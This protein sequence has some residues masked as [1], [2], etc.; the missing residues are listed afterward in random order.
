VWRLAGLVAVGLVVV[1]A[2]PGLLSGPDQRPQPAADVQPSTPPPAGVVGP[3]VEHVI[4]PLRWE[5]RGSQVRS[6]FAIAAV[7]RLS[8]LRQGVDTLLW[9][10]T[11]DGHDHVAVISYR[12]QP[13]QSG[14]DSIEVAALRVRQL[15]D[16]ATARS[17]TI[18]YVSGPD[19]LVG[20]AWQGQDLHTR[21]LVLSRPAPMRL[22]VSSLIDYHADGRISR[23]WQG[24]T[25]HDGVAVTDLGRH[26]DPVII[27][28]AQDLGSGI[29]PTLVEVGGRRALPSPGEVTVAGVSAASYAGPDRTVLVDG[30]ARAVGRLFDLRHADARVL[31][32]GRLAGGLSDSGQR[33]AGRGALVLVR[34]DDGATFQAFVFADQ[35][36]QGESSIANAVRWSVADRLPYAF[37]SYADGAPL[38]LINPT[39]PG[40]ATIT[41]ATGS[42]M[43]VDFNAEGVA[44]VAI[45]AVTGRNISGADVVVRDPSG[46]T[47]L[48]STLVD[49]G[50]VDAFG[51]Y[52]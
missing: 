36:G 42:P 20:L 4:P 39:G 21:L 47:V 49:P 9:A 5:P 23:Q 14:M 8:A 18:G 51:L 48:R 15:A 7:A 33:I 44:T 12:R 37:S 10:G 28:R 29:S 46:G 31:W 24:V 52:L 27:V 45:D 26:V 38:V 16:V 3:N 17:Q 35:L 22:E 34:R 13:N 30:L 43:R 41:P 11:L 6:A 19:G 2:G 25:L 40:S 50:T 32:S 1:L